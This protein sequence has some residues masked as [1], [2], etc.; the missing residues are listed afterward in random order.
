VG[1]SKK[2]ILCSYKEYLYQNLGILHKNMLKITTKSGH[3]G[4]FL[5]DFVLF[6]QNFFKNTRQKSKVKRDDFFSSFLVVRKF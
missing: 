2:D 1:G 4:I 3:F 5:R 6:S